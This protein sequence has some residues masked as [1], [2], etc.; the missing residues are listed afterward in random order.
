MYAYQKAKIIAETLTGNWRKQMV[1]KNPEALAENKR[2]VIIFDIGRIVDS[3]RNFP[4]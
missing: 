3:V 2:N 1:V 4:F